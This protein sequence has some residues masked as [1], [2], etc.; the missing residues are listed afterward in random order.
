[1]PQ[2]N[3]LA[4]SMMTDRPAAAAR[5]RSLFPTLVT[6]LDRLADDAARD[7][8]VITWGCPVPAFGDPTAARVATL[9][10]N[11]SNR[12]FM[13][14]DGA[15]LSGDA[16]RFHTLSS[17]GLSAWDCADADHLDHILASCFDYF[18]GNPYDRW[19][20]RLDTVVS[21]TGASFYD[22]Q[23][24]A[25]HLDLI[26]YATACKWTTLNSKQRSGLLRLAGDTLGL[27]LRRSAIRVLILNGQSVV[28]HFQDATGIALERTDMPEWALPRHSGADVSGYAY[29]GRVDTVSGY[30]LPQELLVLGFNHNLQSSYGVTSSVIQAIRCWV[31][32]VSKE[33]LRLPAAIAT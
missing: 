27:L 30:P 23:S 14:D 21:A 1:M 10:L 9:G 12:E 28:S 8:N 24:P 18:A 29:L 17:L 25:C 3:V 33:A 19:F 22:P 6:L 7:A 2:I 4:D 11:P 26:P 5:Q 20:R 16:R 31:G 15:E 13:G 32:N